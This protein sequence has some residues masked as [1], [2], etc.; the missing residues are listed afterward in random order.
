MKYCDRE[1]PIKCILTCCSTEPIAA[2]SAPVDIDATLSGMLGALA[3]IQRK[4]DGMLAGIRRQQD[5]L[6]V[7]DRQVAQVRQPAQAALYFLFKIYSVCG[8]AGGGTAGC[9]AGRG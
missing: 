9:S 2:V 3:E 6:S 5:Q 1:N 7:L 8:V 4:G